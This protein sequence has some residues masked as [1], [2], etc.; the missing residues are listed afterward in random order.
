MCRFQDTITMKRTFIAV[1]I[2]LKKGALEI[3]QDIKNEFKNDKIK[4]VESWNL[5][6]T[7]Y[8]LG[9]TEE[10]RI[11]GVIETLKENLNQFEK[12]NLKLNGIGV[13]GAARDP[14]VIWIGIDKSEQFQKLKLI[15]NN[16]LKELGFK[17]DEK[18][19][20]PHLTI[21]RIKYIRDKTK[22]KNLLKQHETLKLG[23]IE[24]DKVY[25]YESQ[26]TQRGPIYKILSENQLS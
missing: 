20:K 1:K 21:G 17:V 8:F 10:N 26:L 19:F 18:V 25:Y 13:F 15:I 9:D 4:W 22:L 23:V 12:F 7:L 5:H 2:P 11:E 6:I 16:S 24:V 14:K 3:I